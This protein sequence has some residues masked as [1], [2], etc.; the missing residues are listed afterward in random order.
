MYCLIETFNKMTY[1][2]NNNSGIGLPYFEIAS[3]VTA[4]GLGLSFLSNAVCIVSLLR[5]T[6]CLCHLNPEI[7]DKR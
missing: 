7:V 4:E 2:I 5:K 1:L 6:N 3:A